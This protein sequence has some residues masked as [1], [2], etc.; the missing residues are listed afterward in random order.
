MGPAGGDAMVFLHGWPDS[1]FSFSR[2]MPLLP[3]RLRLFALDQRGFGDSERPERGY[4]IPDLADDVVAFLDAVGVERATVV[5][6]SYGSFVADSRADASCSGAT[7][8]P[9]FPG[10][11]GSAGRGHPRRGAPVYPEIGHCPNWECPD[12]LADDLGALMMKA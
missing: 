12:D 9:C 5:G 8:M 3:P 6:H 4:G 10:R 7:A 11:S 2:V 1:W